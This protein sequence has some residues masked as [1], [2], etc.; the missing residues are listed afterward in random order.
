MRKKRIEELSHT[1]QD[2]LRTLEAKGYI[3]PW[4]GGQKENIISYEEWLAPFAQALARQSVRD[5]AI[6]PQHE[7]KLATDILV[8]YWQD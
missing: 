8:S 1:L 5:R 7:S 4:K 3:T 2:M 6:G